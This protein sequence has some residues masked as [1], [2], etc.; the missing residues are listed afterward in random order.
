MFSI[1]PSTSDDAIFIIKIFSFFFHFYSPLR[2]FH[3]KWINKLN[4]RKLI[5]APKSLQRSVS[6]FISDILKFESL[7]MNTYATVALIIVIGVVLVLVAI[8]IFDKRNRWF[9]VVNQWS[10]IISLFQI[11]CHSWKCQSSRCYRHTRQVY[12]WRNGRHVWKERLP[13]F[14]SEANVAN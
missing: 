9:L 13:V 14:I 6:P 5:Q 3:I 8:W 12:I 7:K 4:M 1:R 2:L 10:I 11:H